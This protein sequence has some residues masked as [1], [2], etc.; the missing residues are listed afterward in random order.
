MDMLNKTIEKNKSLCEKY[1]FLLSPLYRSEPSPLYGTN[2]VDP[3]EKYKFT[4]FDDIPKGW[5]IAFGEQLC[6]ELKEILE[7]NGDLENYHILQI[8]E[9]YGTL[10]WYAN[11][12]TPEISAILDKYENMSAKTCIRCGKPA[13][14]ITTGWISPYCDDCVPMINGKFA[15]TMPIEEI[16]E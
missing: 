3:S 8:K 15:E 4:Y 5:R 16:K 10:R 14:K 1:P 12:E 2:S 11:I 7:R 9:K 13:T 6:Q